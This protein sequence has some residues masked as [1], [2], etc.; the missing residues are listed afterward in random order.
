MDTKRIL[1]VGADEVFRCR[2]HDILEKERGLEIVGECTSVEAALCQID[3]LVPNIVLSEFWLSGMDRVLETCRR[4][5][6]SGFA[7]D[8]IILCGGQ[9]PI[10]YASATGATDY[11]YQDG[12]PEK[13]INAIR[14]ACRLQLLRAKLVTDFYQISHREAIRL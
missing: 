5:T 14:L 1:L 13:I 2:L 11:F 12:K 7:C 6:I 8:V 9:E 4:L 10:S 3:S